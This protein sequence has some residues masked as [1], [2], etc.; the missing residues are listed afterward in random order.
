MFRHFCGCLEGE[1]LFYCCVVDPLENF[2]ELMQLLMGAQQVG[3]TQTNL[4]REAAQGH[5]DNVRRI[6]SQQPTQVH[7][8][9]AQY[10]PPTRRNCRVASH[11][12]CEVNT[13]RN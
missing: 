4:V 6:L 10:T 1:I 13:I 11:R 8:P 5:T 7:V 12:R 9:H 2:L 3:V